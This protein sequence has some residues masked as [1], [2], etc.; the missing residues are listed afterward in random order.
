[1]TAY[2][3]YEDSQEVAAAFARQLAAW[4]SQKPVFHM[5]L[6]GGSTP[7]ILFDLLAAEYPEEIDWSKVHIWWGDERC[8]P[9]DHEE[10][11]YR[12]TRERL[13]DKVA[14]QSAHIH[15]VLGENDPQE[16]AARYAAEIMNH[17]PQVEGAPRF[18]LVMLGMGSD[19]HTASIFPH[20][21]H[22][23]QVPGWCTVGINPDSG[24]RRVSFTGDLIN[25][26]SQI[27]FLVTGA[28]KVEKL[29][30]IWHQKPEAK[31][32]PASLVQPK[33]GALNWYVDKAA[34]ALP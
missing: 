33:D 15:R 16:E 6:S 11:N 12:M 8:V 9:P 18:D 34:A 31:D 14:I 10:S 19:G 24:Q 28:S 1:M 3:I 2:H 21:I 20:E 23:W 30:A 7:K 4:V 22:L 25:A 32:Y 13:L 27:A 5:A 26:A 17:V 29:A